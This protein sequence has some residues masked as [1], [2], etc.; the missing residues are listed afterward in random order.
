LSEEE[1]YNDLKNLLKSLPKVKS[2]NDFETNLFRSLREIESGKYSSQKLRNLTVRPVRFGWLTN[3]VKP[4]YIS[5]IGVTVLLLICIVL[6]FS[7]LPNKNQT[8]PQV[9]QSTS[10]EGNRIEQPPVQNED[11]GITK[12]ETTPSDRTTLERRENVPY[13]PELEKPSS[14][15]EITIPQSIEKS[16]TI[17]PSERS[18]EAE[19]KT[20]DKELKKEEHIDGMRKSESQEAPV[21]KKDEKSNQQDEMLQKVITPSVNEEKVLGKDA[22]KP[23]SVKVMGKMKKEGK[24]ALD[25]K[26]SLKKQPSNKPVLKDEKQPDTTK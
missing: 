11:L 16:E 13:T 3:V 15:Y 20:L 24:K 25:S 4:A 21:M 8:V 19:P 9:T 2:R 18:I 1:K 10:T 17:S 5:A 7:Y 6:Y 14:E 26:D 22:N 23:D 12:N